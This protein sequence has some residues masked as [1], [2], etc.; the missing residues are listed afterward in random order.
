MITNG[1]PMGQPTPPHNVRSSWRYFL[2]PNTQE[3]H[4]PFWTLIFTALAFSIF[5]YMAAQYPLYIASLPSKNNPTINNP[6][7]QDDLKDQSKWGPK[8]LG[9]WVRF[10]GPGNT[11]AYVFD[12][13]YALAWGARYNP[14]L[15]DGQW[16][17]WFTSIGVHA[18]MSHVLSNIVMFVFLSITLEQQYGTLRILLVFL[19]SGLGGNFTS[20]VFEDQCQVVVGAS[21]AVFGFLGLYCA[22]ILLHCQ[23]ISRPLLR[24][25]LMICCIILVLVMDYLKAGP[26]KVSHFTHIGGFVCGLFPSMLFLPSSR[27]SRWKPAHSLFTSALRASRILPPH[28]QLPNPTLSRAARCIY[29]PV[30]WYTLLGTGAVVLVLVFVGMPVYLYTSAFNDLSCPPIM[31]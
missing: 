13:N 25:F 9:R 21:G 6:G 14:K 16:W 31:G 20:A 24:F 11:E 2:V 26:F 17:R 7:W 30:T 15:A 1:Q 28:S 8:S 29:H 4:Y 10:W 23:H 12:A 3:T 19:M 27:D 5:F 22:D 18:S